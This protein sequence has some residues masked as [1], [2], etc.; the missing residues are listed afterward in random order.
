MIKIE[1]NILDRSHIPTII[2]MISQCA[3]LQYVETDTPKSL[4][5]FFD[6]GMVIGL[7]AKS[8]LIAYSVLLKR[9]DLKDLF[10]KYNVVTDR[11]EWGDT[12][13]L[14][15]CVVRDDY[16]GFGLQKRSIELREIVARDS[17]YGEIFTSVHEGNTYSINNLIK[18]G[19]RTLGS[20]NLQYNWLLYGK[21]L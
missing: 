1:H 19:Y 6:R 14:S 5:L 15:T 17:G 16:R 21:N 20:H 10:T 4:E 3:P 18:A 12:V 2:D 13:V 11:N 9:P 8:E 7:F